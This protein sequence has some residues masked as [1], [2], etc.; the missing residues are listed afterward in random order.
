MARAKR[1]RDHVTR[2]TR[3]SAPQRHVVDGLGPLRGWRLASVSRDYFDWIDQ[4]VPWVGVQWHGS[5][6]TL[7]LFGLPA[8]RLGTERRDG[9]H[10]CRSIEGGWLAIEGGEL[11]FA[12]DGD[13]VMM[14]LRGFQPRLP[15]W[16]YRFTQKPIHHLV[17]ARYAS[18]RARREE[19]VTDH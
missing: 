8:I 11:A 1:T 2:A 10:L 6:V 9:N 7:E 17:A 19:L 18:A 3:A 4:C 14:I 16:L 5:K 12:V 13:E 15:Q